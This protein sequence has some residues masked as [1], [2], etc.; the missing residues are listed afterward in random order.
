MLCW[1]LKE[2][3]N[4]IICL[5]TM[6]LEIVLCWLAIA[7]FSI[8]GPHTAGGRSPLWQGLVKSI[9]TQKVRKFHDCLV[10]VILACIHFFFH[11]QLELITIS[12]VACYDPSKHT[13]SLEAI[14]VSF[15]E[16]KDVL[17]F[18]IHTDFKV[19]ESRHNI[20]FAFCI[21][22][23]KSRVTLLLQT[24]ADEPANEKPKN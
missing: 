18:R 13:T 15:T 8:L 23:V 11:M 21:F 17:T 5:L 10:S 3:K 6:S 16:L 14:C 7:H 12:A 9:K 4:E 20:I 1:K 24:V 19:C 2:R 22:E